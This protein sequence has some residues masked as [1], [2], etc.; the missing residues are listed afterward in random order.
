MAMFLNSKKTYAAKWFPLEVEDLQLVNP[1]EVQS[2]PYPAPKSFCDEYPQLRIKLD[3]KY[4][5][6][7]AVGKGPN[8]MAYFDVSLN[9]DLMEGEVVDSKDVKILELGRGS[10]PYDINDSS[11]WCM[12]IE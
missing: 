4:N 5:K 10:G 11:T 7:Q 9:S 6:L 8:G 12:R 3:E 1:N 2:N